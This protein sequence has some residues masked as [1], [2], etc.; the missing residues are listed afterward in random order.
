M[1]SL[2]TCKDGQLGVG[3]RVWKEVG[4]IAGERR[5]RNRGGGG[6]GGRPMTGTTF[7]RNN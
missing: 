3:G 2:E 6:G 4:G 7:H 5:W 1:V